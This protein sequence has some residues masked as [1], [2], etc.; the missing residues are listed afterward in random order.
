MGAGSGWGTGGGSGGRGSGTGTSPTRVIVSLLA[1]GYERGIP[2]PETAHRPAQ[3]D[4]VHA[5]Q[6]TAH[7]APP[8]DAAG[9]TGARRC[10]DRIPRPSA[11]ADALRALRGSKSASGGVMSRTRL[12]NGVRARAID[13]RG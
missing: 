10:T 9:L 13:A 6:G 11:P 2:E 8:H 7:G 4:R 5:R 1:G 12:G 3:A